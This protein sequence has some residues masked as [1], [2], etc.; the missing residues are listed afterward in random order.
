MLTT[1]E[2]GGHVTP[3][4]WLG[5]RL[6]DRGHAVLVMS[7]AAS[8]PEAAALGLE[9][10]PWTRA[11][12]RPD[13]NPLNDPLKE[14]EAPDP[15]SVIARLCEG[16]IVGPAGLYAADVAEALPAR[17]GAVL[18]SQELI[19]GAMMAA[20]A[21]GAPLA[22]FTA[23]L[24]PFGLPGQPPFGAGL[25]PAADE[26]ERMRDALIARVSAQLYDAHLPAL[27]AARAG[28]G[29]QP[30]SSLVAQTEAAARILLGVSAAFDFPADPLPDRFIYVGQQAKLPGWVAPWASPWSPGDPRPL[31][32]VSFSTLYQRQEDLIGRVISA[33]QGRP[34][35]AVVTLGPAVDPGAFQS[36]EQIR[37]LPSASHD[38][39]MPELSAM[40]THAGHGSVVRPLLGGVPLL[41]LPMGRDQPDNAARVEARGA[42]LRLSPEASSEQIGA[43]LDR[44]LADARY[45]ERARA[46]GEAIRAED[47]RPAARRSGEARSGD[48][49]VIELERLA[50]A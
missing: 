14:W 19:F 34:V 21:A 43:A 11:P 18:V 27:N 7:D 15:A 10:R 16:L 30:L 2:G 29:L 38:A 4:L 1:W 9:F 12:S 44:L 47:A 13:K 40:I 32:L 35:R 36:T 6:A 22:L 33:V 37:V 3:M 31:V 24:W 25:L 46:L 26:A 45:R 17:P 28:L 50:G 39:L 49:A 48:R 20:E 8:G 42:G 41:M 23:N 5:R